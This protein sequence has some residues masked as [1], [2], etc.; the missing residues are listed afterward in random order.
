MFNILVAKL[1]SCS[2]MK[3]LILSCLSSCIC[4]AALSFSKMCLLKRDK[5]EPNWRFLWFLET[6][7]LRIN[8]TGSGQELTLWRILYFPSGLSTSSASWVVYLWNCLENLSWFFSESKIIP[9]IYC[10]TRLSMVLGAV[11][12]C[13]CVRERSSS[14]N[15]ETAWRAVVGFPHLFCHRHASIPGYHLQ[16]L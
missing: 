1:R 10:L 15:L 3:D 2:F 7:D 4:S 6:N 16:G 5:M 12:C 14:R 8:Q 9:Q 13:Y 11:L